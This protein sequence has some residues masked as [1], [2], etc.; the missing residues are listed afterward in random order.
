M[1]KSFIYSIVLTTAF[2][3][4]C[5]G[6][7]DDWA[8]PQGFDAEEAKN[9]SVNITPAAAIE[10]ENVTTETIQLFTASVDAPEGMEVTAYEAVLSKIDENGV[11]QGKT[12]LAADASGNVS[13]KEV[14]SAVESYYGKNPIARN[15]AVTVMAYIK[16]AEQ[17][18]C[19]SSNQVEVQVTLIKPD[20]S[21]SYYLVGDMV[22]WDEA[23][24]IKFAHSD[25]NVYD[26]PVFTISITTTADDQYWKI[27]P[28]KNID[29]G[30]FW[31]NPGV[32][33]PKVDGDDAMSGQLVNEGACR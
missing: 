13:T 5:K 28:Q 16:Q 33:G 1:R 14:V 29:A 7:Y 11:A 2:F 15:L 19:V 8:A 3:S 9:I 25:V 31:A 20:I 32:V 10:M 12:I 24:M 18:F 26:D 30:D 4:G 22:G 27:I 6:D 17:A 23:S 21:E